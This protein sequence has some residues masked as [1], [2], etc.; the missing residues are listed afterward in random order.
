MT[1]KKGKKEA[2][3]EDEEETELIQNSSEDEMDEDGDVTSVATT[4]P[5]KPVITDRLERPKTIDLPTFYLYFVVNKLEHIHRN[6]FHLPYFERKPCIYIKSWW[7]DQRR[8]LYN[9]NIIDNVADKLVS[10]PLCWSFDE[11]QFVH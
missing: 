6:Y 7:Q 5:M 3:D 10:P 1:T 2:G 9:A 4:P 8:R 11:R